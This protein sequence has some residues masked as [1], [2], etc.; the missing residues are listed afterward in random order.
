MDMELFFGQMEI[1]TMEIGKTV[2]QTEKVP[3]YGVMEENM[4]ELLKM[5]NCM[6]KEA[7]TTLMVKNTKENF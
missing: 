1:D 2:K 5:I 4:W 6:E 7:F 3:S